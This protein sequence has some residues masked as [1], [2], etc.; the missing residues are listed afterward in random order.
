MLTSS[1]SMVRELSTDGLKEALAKT[2]AALE[3]PGFEEWQLQ[4]LPARDWVD[5]G[6]AD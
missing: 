6:R 3:L 5:P 1:P 2:E 4:T